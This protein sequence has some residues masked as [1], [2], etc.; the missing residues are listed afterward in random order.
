MGL[1]AFGPNTTIA[2]YKHLIDDDRWDRMVDLFREEN[3]KIFKLSGHSAFSACLQVS[4]NSKL[5]NT[6]FIEQ[7]NKKATRCSLAG[8]HR[9][10]QNANVPPRSDITLRC[11]PRALRSRQRLAVCARR[12]SAPHMRGDRRSAR[13]AKSAGDAR[14]R[15]RLRQTRSRSNADAR[16][17]CRLPAHKRKLLD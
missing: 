2:K 9:S 3:A 12:K 7:K 10:A 16:R 5:Y 17:C 13:R 4:S 8:G 14:E 6:R 15:P 1:F 11:V